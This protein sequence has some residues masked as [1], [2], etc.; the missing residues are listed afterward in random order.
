MT[1]K[2]ILTKAIS[3]AVE[4]G[5]TMFGWGDEKWHI[6]EKQHLNYY[7]EVE[8]S[9]YSV[10]EIIFS[11]EFAK[12]FFGDERRVWNGYSGYLQDDEGNDDGQFEE[13]FHIYVWEYHLQQMVLEKEPLKYLEKYLE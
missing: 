5:W 11:H 1:N 9:L 4:N 7:L 3:K 8:E 2:E 6:E 12:Y 10:N 13:A